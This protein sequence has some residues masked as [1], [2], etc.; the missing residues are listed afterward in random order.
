MKSIALLALLVALTGC[1]SGENVSPETNSLSRGCLQSLAPVEDY[2]SGRTEPL[3]D[4]SRAELRVL[5]EKPY[6]SC[7]RKE[8]A[9]YRDEVLVPWAKGLDG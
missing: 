4:V 1:T 2:M 8:F 5:L 6:D 3:D 9:I 7:S